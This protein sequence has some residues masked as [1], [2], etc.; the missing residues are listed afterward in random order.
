MNSFQKILL[1]S[2]ITLIIG[3][4]QVITNSGNE[5][6]E[7]GPEEE[8]DWLIPED[9]IFIA[10]AGIPSIDNPKFKPTSETEYVDDDRLIIGVRVGDTI[11]GYPHQVMDYH[12]VVNDK[13]GDLPYSMT[14]CPLTGTGIAWERTIDGDPVEFGVSGMLF[15]N[16]LIAYDRKTDT[17]Y[18]QMQMRAVNG[19]RKGEQLETLQVIQTKWSTWKKMF[20]EAQVLTTQTGYQRN[21][22]GYA[23]GEDYLDLNTPPPFPL[24]LTDEKTSLGY[25]KRLYGILSGDFDNETVG[26][27]GRELFIIDNLGEGINLQEATLRETTYIVAGSSDQDF[28]VAFEKSSDKT[29][30]AVQNSL[31]IIMEDQDGNRWDVFGYAVEGPRKGE[32][33]TPANAYYGYAFAWFDFFRNSDG[34]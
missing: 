10:F 28:V 24:E 21:Y 19:P 20:P 13:I 14:Y 7:P 18:S 23:Y 27:V 12:E 26:T 4:D 5:N 2:L 3:C 15:R 31:P 17:N 32:R 22:G 29:F 16:N 8:Q 9:E 33:L 11:K 6:Q 1:I 34:F 30:S 25:K